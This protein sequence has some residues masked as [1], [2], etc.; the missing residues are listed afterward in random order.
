MTADRLNVVHRWM[1]FARERCLSFVPQ[2]FPTR[3]GRTCVSQAGWLWELLQWLPGTADK[4]DPAAPARVATACTTLAQFHEILAQQPL[5]CQPCPGVQRRL[6][7]LREWLALRKAGWRPDV[8][9]QPLLP[10]TVSRQAMELLREHGRHIPQQLA[11]W[12][13]TVVTVQPC[14]CDIWRDHVL[15]E[16]EDVVGLVD[17]GSMKVDH[18]SVDLA[19][20]LGSFAGSAGEAWRA[21]LEAYRRLRPLSEREAEL[22]AVLDWSGTLLALANWLRWLF[23][24]YRS[25]EDMELVARRLAVLVSRVDG[26]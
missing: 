17:Y 22:I 16:G 10:A 19:R 20:L 14:L 4:Q 8:T 24:E 26:T 23:H 13:D 15:F 9:T 21:G 18:V 25:Y 2:I 11:P 5:S 6:H 1:R 3:S 12:T 7:C